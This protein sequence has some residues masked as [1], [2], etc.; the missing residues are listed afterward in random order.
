M[1][2]IRAS[3]VYV[4][5]AVKQV[6]DNV[7]YS[8]AYVNAGVLNLTTV[9]VPQA[10]VLAA[11]KGRVGNPNARAWTFSLDGH[12]FYV[13]HLG[14]T[15][16]LVYDTYSKEWSVW[17]NDQAIRWKA[18]FGINW[19][20]AGPFA[21]GFGSNVITIDDTNGAV[22]FLS[23]N[24]PYDDDYDVGEDSRVA[25]QRIAQG[26]IIIRGRTPTPCYGV[27]LTGSFGDVFVDTLTAVTLEVS[28]DA[29][30]TYSDCGTVTVTATDY[31]A[32]VEWLSLGLMTAP[33]RMFRITDSGS[34]DRI[35]GL[36]LLDPQ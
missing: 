29:G 12:D 31:A 24:Y 23:P 15:E 17:G 13:L 36:E 21:G 32:R 33:G 28:D 4:L 2:D 8:Q 9:Q 27:S 34:L 25:F 6:S 20:G 3:Q 30:R 26:Q 10:Y 16:T 1:T 22:Y 5:A 35:D 7:N 19:V 14:D 18:A 11:V